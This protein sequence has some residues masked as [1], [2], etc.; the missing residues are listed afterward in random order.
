[1]NDKK[2]TGGSG[3]LSPQER[4]A[5]LNGL[6]NLPPVH[7]KIVTLYYFKDMTIQAIAK[8]LGLPLLRVHKMHYDAIVRLKRF[9]K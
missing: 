5:L 3:E 7:A 2:G 9:V 1:M 8:K 6:V 4:K